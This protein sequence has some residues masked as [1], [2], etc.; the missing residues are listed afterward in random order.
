[1]KTPDAVLSN[2]NYYNKLIEN[3][4]A[5]LDELIDIRNKLIQTFDEKGLPLKSN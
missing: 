1:M 4:R 3:K 2:I 5:E